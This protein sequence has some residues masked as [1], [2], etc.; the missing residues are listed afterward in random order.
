MENRT[1]EFVTNVEIGLC[2]ICFHNMFLLIE[3][4]KEKMS[5]EEL[6]RMLLND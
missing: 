2:S 5:N 6:L 4:I 1:I 3:M